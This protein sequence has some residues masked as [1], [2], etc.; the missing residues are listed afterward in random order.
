MDLRSIGA[1]GAKRGASRTEAAGGRTVRPRT[2]TTGEGHASASAV[3]AVD[4]GALVATQRHQV[5]VNSMNPI[6]THGRVTDLRITYARIGGVSRECSFT[7]L[8][9][10]PKR[11]K[12]SLLETSADVLKGLRKYLRQ[13]NNLGLVEFKEDQDCTADGSARSIVGKMQTVFADQKENRTLYIDKLTRGIPCFES[14]F[15]DLD[16]LKSQLYDEDEKEEHINCTRLTQLHSILNDVL[17]YADSLEAVPIETAE[18]AHM[19]YINSIKVELQTKFLA[20]EESSKALFGIRDTWLDYDAAGSRDAEGFS[21]LQL[22]KADGLVRAHDTLGLQNGLLALNI[23]LTTGL[24]LDQK[25]MIDYMMYTLLAELEAL[26]GQLS[27]SSLTPFSDWYTGLHALY[28]KTYQALTHT[29]AP[30]G[31]VVGSVLSLV[32]LEL[33]RVAPKESAHPAIKDGSSEAGEDEY[34]GD[35]LG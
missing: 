22:E 6:V 27:S 30:I 15:N 34:K 18:S 14:I 13:A 1:I 33:S 5:G 35:D 29:A 28:I 3:E 32:G 12:S 10:E 21:P 2:E 9:S 24:R 19:L 4:H 25:D 20:F 8:L 11:V 16:T 23:A 26:F 7:D 17:K 31:G